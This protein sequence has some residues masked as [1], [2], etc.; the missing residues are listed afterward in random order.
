MSKRFSRGKAAHKAYTETQSL[1]DEFLDNTRDKKVWT[2]YDIKAVKPLNETQEHM[3]RSYYE[4]R[5]IVALG[6]AGTGK[7]MISL[8]LGLSDVFDHSKPQDKI[9][10][11]RSVVPTREVGFL[12]GTLDEKLAIYELPYKE[13]VGSLFTRAKSYENMKAAGKVEFMCTSFIRGL[14]WDNAIVILD[15][16]QNCTFH[17]INSVATRLGR[18]SRLIVLGDTKQGDLDKREFSGIAKLEQVTT[19]MNAFDNIYFTPHDIVRSHFVKAWLTA[20]EAVS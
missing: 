5:N 4:G 17:E 14:T 1:T 3:F 19:V 16:A 10:I 18:N 7:S 9:I 2:K 13:I 11:V 15:E 6:S 8:Y 20:V 12:P